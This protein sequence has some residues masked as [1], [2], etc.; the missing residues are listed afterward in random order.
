MIEDH[1]TPN[2]I[3]KLATNAKVGMVILSR[4][5][6]GGDSDPDEA[7]SDGVAAHYSGT[8]VVAEDLMRF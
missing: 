4:L 1:T 2:E 7:Y 3:G 5:I 6:P 8:V